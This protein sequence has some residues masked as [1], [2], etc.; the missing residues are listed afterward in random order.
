MATALMGLLF[1]REPKRTVCLK[2]NAPK[3]SGMIK[4]ILIDYKVAFV[5]TLSNP[6]ARW[7]LL[8]IILRIWETATS[9]F[10]LPKYM[11]VYPGRYKEFG[12]L[13]SISVFI[14]GFT[15]NVTS[16]ILLTCLDANSPMTIPILCAVRNLIDIP[17][18]GLMFLQ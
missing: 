16:G 10:F 2:P 17:S 3:G 9:S 8:G 15:S 7:V 18:L 1:M 4:K 12:N 6:A 11:E 5:L 13:S 14:G